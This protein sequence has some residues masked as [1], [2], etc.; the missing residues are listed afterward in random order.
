MAAIDIDHLRDWVGKR[1]AADQVINPFPANALAGLLDHAAVFE[2]GDALPLPWHWLYFLEA[3]LHSGT[4]MDGHPARGGFLPPVPLPRR[5]WASGTL[6]ASAALLIGQPANKISTVRSVD[7]K[8]GKTGPLLFVT[9]EHELHQGGSLCIREVQN[10]V[11]RDAP[12]AAVP[13]PPG[14]S[15]IEKADWTHVVKPDP[16]QLFRFSALTYNGHRIH[17][18]R[19]YAVNQEFY[20]A[21]V[22]HGPLLATML[23]DSLRREYPGAFITEFRFRALRPAFDTDAIRLCGRIEGTQVQLWTVDPEGMVGM[24]AS[25]VIT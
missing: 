18:D 6:H 16:I 21:L 11:Y 5:M 14:E 10:L 9:V 23:L 25:A 15:A 22:V 13:L 20:P 8:E 1:I 24:R 17:Y 12:T 19:D 3:P 4:G 7:L 2:P